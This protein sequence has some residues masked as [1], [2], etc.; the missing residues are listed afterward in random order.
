MTLAVAVVCQDGVVVAADS[1]TTLNNFRA[2][3][4]GSDATHKV[5]GSG[6]VAIAT[7][8]EAF[9]L[10]RSVAHH[11]ANFADAE[12]GN[13]HHPR[14]AAEALADHFGDLCDQ[15]LPTEMAIA[16]QQDMALGFLVA[17]HDQAGVGEAWEVR[18]PDREVELAATMAEGGAAVWRGQGDVVSRLL[19]G[20]DESLLERV[21]GRYGLRREYEALRP[22]LR[23][24][25]Y[26]IPF[27]TM[28]LQDAVDLAALCLRV[29]AD[30]QR[31]SLGASLHSPE[32]SW[33]GV[34]G[35]TEIAAVT[36]RGGFSWVQR[37][38]LRAG[39]Q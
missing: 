21:V 28:N 18:L 10:G 5:F 36:L 35:P 38:A 29:T 12:S 4:V 6:R 34:G 15:Q 17:G 3:R 2:S 32:F 23:E 39:D 1:R 7:W 37:T 22:L 30:V 26:R 14:A 19:V 9:V 25:G 33:P 31:F 8:G 16:A 13:C 20:F 11:M 27:E 24:C